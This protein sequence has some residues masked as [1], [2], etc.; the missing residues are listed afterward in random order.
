MLQANRRSKCYDC[1][2]GDRDQDFCTFSANYRSSLSSLDLSKESFFLDPTNGYVPYYGDRSKSEIQGMINGKIKVP[3]K[4]IDSIL[5]ENNVTDIDL[6]VIDVDGS[7]PYTLK[8]LTLAKWNPT[9]LLLEYSVVGD[10][11]FDYAA[12]NGYYFATRCGS[13]DI[14]CRKK[15]DVEIM[16]S[17]RVIGKRNP[18]S[19]KHPLERS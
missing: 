6:I 15:S 17:V 19:Q 9:I 3:M 7:E 1:A 4:K 2:A 12:K 10:F 16:K 14:F 11:V 13:D 8:G 18:L 5:E